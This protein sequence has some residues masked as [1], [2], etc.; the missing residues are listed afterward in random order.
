MRCD[1][2]RD[3]RGGV[4]FAVVDGHDAVRN[5]RES[6]GVAVL[7]EAFVGIDG[8][9]LQIVVVVDVEFHR[10]AVVL[11]AHVG[12]EHDGLFVVDREIERERVVVALIAVSPVE[13]ALHREGID[14][15]VCKPQFAHVKLDQDI[16]ACLFAAR[17]GRLAPVVARLGPDDF[18]R[19]AVRDLHLDALRAAQKPRGDRIEH[20]GA[21]LGGS[22]RSVT[23]HRDGHRISL[24]KNVA[25]RAHAPVA[26]RIVS[27]V[28]RRGKSRH[29]KRCV[30]V[31]HE[32][33]LFQHGRVLLRGADFIFADVEHGSVRP[34]AVEC[35]VGKIEPDPV[36]VQRI[37]THIAFDIH[38]VDKVGIDVIL[39]LLRKR[40]GDV[41]LCRGVAAQGDRVPAQA[42]AALRGRHGIGIIRIEQVGKFC[43]RSVVAGHA[44]GEHDGIELIAQGL[45]RKVCDVEFKFIHA[46]TVGIVPQRKFGLVGAVHREIC[47]G[48]DRFENVGKACALL[49]GRIRVAVFVVGDRR[50][51]H[52]ETVRQVAHFARR[53]RGIH[54]L[55]V[56]ADENERTRKVGRRH[57]R[58]ADRIVFVSAGVGRSD[59]PAVRRDVG[60]KRQV[61]QNAPR[62]E[63]GH[64]RA[65]KVVLGQADRPRALCHKDLAV[66]HRDEAARNVPARTD[67]HAQHTRNIV[68]NDDTHGPH[69]LRD[70]NFLLERIPAAADD[71]DL[72]AD[73]DPGVVGFIPDAGDHDKVE[74]AL[75]LVAEHTAHEVVVLFL[76]DPAGFAE[77]DLRSVAE[78]EIGRLDAADRSDRK[79][80]RIRSGRTD[81]ARIGIACKVGVAVCAAIGG[82]IIVAC[83]HDKADAGRFD[84]VVDIVDRAAVLFP[85]EAARGTETHVDGVHTEQDGIVERGQNGVRFGAVVVVGEHLE[86]GDLRAGRNARNAVRLARDDA[87]DV[88]AV[89]FGRVDVRIAVRIVVGIGKFGAQIQIVF[90]DAL[91][92]CRGKRGRRKL[93]RKARDIV[94]GDGGL[95]IVEHHIEHFVRVVGAR[96]EHGDDGAR[97]VIVDDGRVVNT[98]RTVHIDVVF[99]DR[100]RHFVGIRK[101]DLL[102]ARI[103]FES[104]EVFIAD[105]R[106]E[107]AQNGAVGKSRFN[108]IRRER[109]FRTLAERFYLLDSPDALRTEHGLLHGD[110]LLVRIVEQGR[111]VHLDDDLDQVFAVRFA[112]NVEISREF[113]VIGKRH[114]LRRSRRRLITHGVRDRLRHGGDH[115]R[116]RKGE[117]EKQA[118]RPS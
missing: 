93:C 74:R 99:R 79:G 13:E 35:K 7:V 112:G 48:G 84:A 55:D 26:D 96:V 30:H 76:S 86:R 56:L 20:I 58:T 72:A 39:G 59:L 15:V 116:R 54:I 24:R 10:L 92:V 46:R 61:G 1:I 75:V 118:R 3:A 114:V 68:V 53:E 109:L 47:L 44:L 83:R 101:N 45:A 91:A 33:V 67:G 115:D 42:D 50:R 9:A 106:R 8:K 81:R 31:G 94:L 23:L 57:G 38:A 49:S 90:V 62:G 73:V 70:G 64:E 71:G 22:Q 102:D 66:V 51:A 32:F 40:D 18:S 104:G 98:R 43:D 87:G 103:L 52:H 4:E 113:I 11:A 78:Q 97:P 63:I 37:Q 41:D 117:N 111:R 95:G 29:G 107:A 110:P 19:R 85:R 6:D 82:R 60:R 25:V 89:R 69:R 17:R 105:G 16:A 88:R 80:R 100:L 5:R 14:G 28:V 36:L 27:V 34:V 21:V 12:V 77:I 108:E 65:G 2:Q